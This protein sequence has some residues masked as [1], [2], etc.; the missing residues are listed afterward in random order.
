MY[1][2]EAGKKEEGSARG[3]MGPSGDLCGGEKEN[4]IRRVS[5]SSNTQV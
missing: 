2:R 3:T 5:K 4:L 1:R